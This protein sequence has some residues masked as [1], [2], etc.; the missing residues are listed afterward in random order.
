MG[1]IRKF[2]CSHC[3][4]IVENTFEESTVLCGHCESLCTM[5]EEIGPGVMIDDFLILKLLGQGGMGN[6]YLAHEYALDRQV[7]LKI[8]KES[9]MSDEEYKYEFI[10]EAR[11]VAS[12]NH[13]NIIQAFKV[14]EENDIVYFVSEYVEGKNLK[15]I[16]LI[17]LIA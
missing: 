17:S 10:Q 1:K 13:P 9:F 2:Q 5:P 16:L 15:D 4:G 12:L 14:G 7:A 11:S 3:K 6:V 8:L